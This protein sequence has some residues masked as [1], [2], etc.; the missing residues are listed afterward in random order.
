MSLFL[1]VQSAK[2]IDSVHHV[3]IQSWWKSLILGWLISLFITGIFAFAGFALPTQKLLSSRYYH[4]TNPKSLKKIYELLKVDWFRKF[5]LMTI[6][7]NKEQQKR[8]FDGTLAGIDKLLLHSMKSEF[9][10]VIPFVLTLIIVGYFMI[11]GQYLL[12][13]FTMIFN[14]IGNVYPVILQRH[15]RMRI[16][17]LYQRFEKTE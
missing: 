7:K 11:N 3:P 13:I 12:S 4:V 15:H 14:L 1:V 2:I 8:Y 10:H 9:G 16:Q 5:L 17:K 6:W